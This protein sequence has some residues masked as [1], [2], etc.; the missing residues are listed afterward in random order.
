MFGSILRPLSI[1]L[2]KLCFD[3]IATKLEIDEAAKGD[4]V[5]EVLES[6]NWGAP[7]HNGGENEEYVFEDA[8]QSHDQG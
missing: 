8:T 7:D 2:R 6:R 1:G 3:R 5:T 4:S